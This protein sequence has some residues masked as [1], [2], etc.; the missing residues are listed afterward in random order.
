[1]RTTIRGK[2]LTVSDKD[3]AYIERKMQRLERML[4]DRSDMDIEINVLR[5]RL[6]REG[7]NLKTKGND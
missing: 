6:Q 1:M 7:V 5:D 2:N 4:D 3:R